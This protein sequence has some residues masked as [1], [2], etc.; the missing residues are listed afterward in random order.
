MPA[1]VRHLGAGLALGVLTGAVA[2]GFMALL[3]EDPQFSWAGTAFIVG[4]F[5]VAGL[6]FAAAHDVKLRQ[7]SRWWKL[8]TLPAAVLGFGPGA[9][10]VP[11]IVGMALIG[12]RNRWARTSGVVLLLGFLALMPTL[13]GSS[14]EP[15]TTRTLAGFVVMFLVCAVVAAGARTA[16]TGWAPKG[17]RGAVASR[18]AE[19]DGGEGSH[20]GGDSGPAE[21]VLDLHDG[22][23]EQ[24]LAVGLVRQGGDGGVVLV[25]PDRRQ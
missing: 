8:L 23:V 17:S 4:V 20:R 16:L 11:P 3:T 10:M 2:R 13:V 7:R 22:R 19:R 15:F 14:D 21:D 6:S 1:L 18:E 5:A 9:L 12:S 24:G 25:Q